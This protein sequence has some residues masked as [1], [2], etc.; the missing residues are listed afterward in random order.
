MEPDGRPGNLY[1]V[2][3]THSQARRYY[4]WFGSKQDSQGFYE[5]AALQ[6]LVDHG[7]FGQANWLFELGCGTG[8]FA[9]RLFRTQLNKQAVYLGVDLSQTMTSLASRRLVEYRDRAQ[10][11]RSGGDVAFPLADQCVD[12]VIA[13][14]VLDLLS[15]EDIQRVV[16]ESHRVLRPGGRLCLAGLTFGNS[17][18]S[19][20]VS[21]TWAGLFHL[22]APMVG[23]CR[24]QQLRP[25]LDSLHWE[26]A[27]HQVIIQFGVA[28]EV[29]IA[30]PRH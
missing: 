11:V 22:Y 10:V 29:I 8:R 6:A 30:Q 2:T 5:D 1:I 23:G 15:G 19:R 28:S 7:D 25:Y 4:D 14:Y 27:Y 26:I 20:L 3:L 13:T 9:E 12:R 21:Y 18:L 16:S 24:P 17:L